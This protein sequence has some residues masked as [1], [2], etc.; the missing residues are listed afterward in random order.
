MTL[1]WRAMVQHIAVV[2]VLNRK[3]IKNSRKKRYKNQI[4]EPGAACFGGGVDKFGFGLHAK[5]YYFLK[6][7]FILSFFYVEDEAK[8]WEVINAIIFFFSSFFLLVSDSSSLRSLTFT[9]KT[10]N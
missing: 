7:K 2:S 4:E 6:K 10:F 9:I 1:R 3:S 5:S 8:K